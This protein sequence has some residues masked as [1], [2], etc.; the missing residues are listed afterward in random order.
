MKQYLNG[1]QGILL[2]RDKGY[3]SHIELWNKTHFVQ[4]GSAGALIYESEFDQPSV[5][6]WE[7]IEE[8][9]GLDPVPG[10]LR[11]WW[12]VTDPITYYYYF[13]D[14]H[15]VTYTKVE[16]TNVLDP[17][18][19]QPG[20]EGAVTVS[21]NSTVVVIDWNPADGGQTKETFT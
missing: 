6:F 1:K 4:D 5:L 3:G 9:P 2:F 12:K 13:S 19:R 7:V 8:T 20:N 16:P 15:V 18:V 11:G 10:W 17:P 21:Q 14:Q